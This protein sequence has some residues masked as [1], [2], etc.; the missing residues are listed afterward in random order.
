MTATEQDK[1]ATILNKLLTYE[2]SKL[3]LTLQEYVLESDNQSWEGSSDTEVSGFYRVLSDML[4]YL[5]NK[6]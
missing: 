3:G 2:S 4:L 1:R 6:V 5:D